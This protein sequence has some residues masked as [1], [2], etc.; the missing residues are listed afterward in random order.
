VPAGSFVADFNPFS[1]TVQV[2]ANGMIHEP[3]FYFNTV[4]SGPINPWLGTSYTWSHGG[5]T[6]DFQLRHGVHWTDGP[7]DSDGRRPWTAC[8]WCC[9][10]GTRWR[11]SARADRAS[12]RS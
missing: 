4:K 11:W 8:R 10:R 5:T 6:L 12:R 7:S 3:L 1:P 9:A 2:P